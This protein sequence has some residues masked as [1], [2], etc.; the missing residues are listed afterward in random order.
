MVQEVKHSLY[1]YPDGDS[2]REMRRSKSLS[3]CTGAGKWLRWDTWKEII[4]EIKSERWGSYT[5][6]KDLS[7]NFAFDTVWDVL[8]AKKRGKADLLLT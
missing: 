7:T 1:G 8:E 6:Y 3:L 4:K 5:Y 2:Q